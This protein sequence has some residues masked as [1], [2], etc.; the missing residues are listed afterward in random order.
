MSMARDSIRDR[1][2]VILEKHG[3]KPPDNAALYDDLIDEVLR[4]TASDLAKTVRDWW[5]SR[6]AGEP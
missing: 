6:K 4:S 5:K 1:L 3:I 2:Q